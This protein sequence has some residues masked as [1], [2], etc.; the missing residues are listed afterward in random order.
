[1]TDV[2]I[3]LIIS[4][5]DHVVEPPTLWTDRLPELRPTAGYPGDS[6]RFKAEIEPLQRELAIDDRALWRSR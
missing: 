6:R 5:D 2:E 1:M 3:P 4:G